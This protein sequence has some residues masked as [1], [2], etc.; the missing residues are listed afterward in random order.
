MKE[1]LEFKSF[2]YV[3]K[4]VH[5]SKDSEENEKTYSDDI[6]FIQVCSLTSSCNY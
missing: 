4:N 2:I 6:I 3:M 5:S 1:M